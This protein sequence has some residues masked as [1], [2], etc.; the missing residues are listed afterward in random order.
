MLGHINYQEKIIFQENGICQTRSPATLLGGFT[1]ILQ[2][3]KEYKEYVL[4]LI[5]KWEMKF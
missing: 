3:G 5:A 2:S 4:S 1:I